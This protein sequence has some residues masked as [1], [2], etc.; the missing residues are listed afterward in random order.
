V[1]VPLKWLSDFVD[2]RGISAEILAQRLQS[3]GVAVEH[4]ERRNQGVSGVVVGEI[5]SSNKREVLALG[6]R[7]G[8]ASEARALYEARAPEA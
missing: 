1:K 8:P 4:V 2:L 6:D 5:G 3:V 7:R